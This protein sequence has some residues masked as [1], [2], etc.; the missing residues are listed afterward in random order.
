[1]I[2]EFCNFVILNLIAD[3]VSSEEMKSDYELSFWQYMGW[4][5]RGVF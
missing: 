5:N 2:G 1:M 4:I 3:T